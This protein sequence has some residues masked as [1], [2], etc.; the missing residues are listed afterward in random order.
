MSITTDSIAGPADVADTGLS[1][2][3]DIT[4]FHVTLSVADLFRSVRFYEMLLGC[5]PA[6]L[7]QP[8]ARFELDDPAL[9]LVLYASPRPPGGAL[10]HV[11]LRVGT[12]EELV[13][14][15]QRLEMA[16]IATQRQEGVE[17][18]YARQT[19]FWAA[20][21][22]GTL[23]ELY[24]LEGDT[25][26]SGFEDPPVAKLEPVVVAS[27]TH[28]LTEPFP[29]RVPHDD[30]S[31]DEVKLEGTFNVP[32]AA[33]RR[34]AL[35]AEVLR[36]LKPGGK[37]LVH[38]LMCDV[39]FPGEP[40]LPGLAALVRY[41]PVERESLDDL[42]QA[43]FVGLF[44]EKLSDVNCIG[45][46]GVDLRHGLLV[47]YRPAIAADSAKTRVVYRGPFAM[48][49]DERGETFRRGEP[50]MVTRDTIELLRNGPA[51]DQFAFLNE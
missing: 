12:T 38:G 13:A 34:T 35:L 30:A 31:L 21:P 33:D 8:Y 26:H 42:Q 32:I 1:Q 49:R 37:V 5:P 36:V 10:S 51:A 6:L 41:V 47:G 28:R 16:G 15:Q 23:W 7:H 29:P 9:V 24:A 11:G 2:L 3:P 43:G 44:F 19:K 4:R 25:D 46:P 45:A 20:D 50:V 17:C 39:T 22:D 14:I 18:C 40:K 27:W 48:V